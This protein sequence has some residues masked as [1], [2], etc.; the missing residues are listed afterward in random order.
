MPIMHDT[1]YLKYTEKFL[2]G[3]IYDTNVGTTDTLIRPVAEGW[4]VYGI[5]E[6]ITYMKE[7]GKTTFLVPSKLA[8]GASGSYSI[9][10]YTAL[11]FDIELV[12]V[13][14]GPGK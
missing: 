8:Y 13:K 3:T 12:R 4:I 7:G 5:D 9:P 2:D 1:A 6:G 11:L 10:G 14:P